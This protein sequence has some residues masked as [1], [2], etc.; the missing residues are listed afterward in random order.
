VPLRLITVSVNSASRFSPSACSRQ[1]YNS[2]RLAWGS[3]FARVIVQLRTPLTIIRGELELVAANNR[4]SPE[5]NQAVT[6]ALEEMTR[7]SGVVDS[8]ITHSCMES[9]LG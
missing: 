7:L 9:L 3:R 5:V 8:L 1:I 4:K 2:L 6:S